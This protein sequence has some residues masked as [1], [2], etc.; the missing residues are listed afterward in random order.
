MGEEGDRRLEEDQCLGSREEGEVLSV[1][2]EGWDG[3]VRALGGC[4]S[5]RSCGEISAR[6]QG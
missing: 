3:A 1:A 2:V 5:W 4:L 6:L